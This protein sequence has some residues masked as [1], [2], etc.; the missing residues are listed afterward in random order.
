MA[1]R[2]CAGVDGVGG[3]AGDDGSGGVEVVGFGFGV[4]SGEFVIVAKEVE[5]IHNKILQAFKHK[6]LLPSS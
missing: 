6:H 5:K 2:E 1:G 3:T 4:G